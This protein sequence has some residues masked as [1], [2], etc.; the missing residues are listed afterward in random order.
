M[1]KTVKDQII[2]RI[3]GRGRGWAFSPKDFL[4]SFSRGEISVA[5]AAL[6]KESKIR[7]VITGIYD[8]PAY[9]DILKEDVSPDI[10]SVAKALARKNDWT[11]YP[12]GNTA[13]NYLGLSTQVVSQAIYL[14]DGPNKKYKVGSTILEFRSSKIAEAK[15]HRESSTLVVQAIKAIGEKSI[16]RAF[17]E[18][19][20]SKYSKEEWQK[21]KHDCTK[22]TGWIYNNIEKIADEI[23]KDK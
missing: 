15:L 10:Y 5:L 20:A 22:V 21:I 19:M 8:Y 23:K 17:L 3:Y 2:S 9:S 18:D 1:G 11:I 14:S 4:G 13:L 12:D 6:T 7:R 16:T